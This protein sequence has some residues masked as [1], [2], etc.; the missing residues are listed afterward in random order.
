MSAWASGVTVV[1]TRADG[2][3]HGITASSFTSVSLDPPLIERFR[4]DLAPLWPGMDSPGATLGL[5]VSGGGD[6]LALLLLARAALPGRVK[7]ATVDHGLRPD[8]AAEARRAGEFCAALGI[9]HTIR[10]WEG[11]KPVAGLQAAA[12]EA[13]YRLLA[14]AA[15][16]ADCS[17]VMTGHTLDDQAETVAMRRERGAGRGLSGIAPATLHDKRIWFVRPLIG[18]RRAASLLRE[19][20][21]EVQAHVMESLADQR[22]ADVLARL[23]YKYD[24]KGFPDG[25]VPHTE[26]A[27]TC[28]QVCKAWRDALVVR[29]SSEEKD[30]ERRGVYVLRLFFDA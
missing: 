8:S 2:L 22:L 19:L 1:T 4:G 14:E 18:Q 20:P 3:A 5:A 15:D 12:R 7:A 23:A 29:G 11:E 30:D 26:H 24:V 10:R 9:P 28:M 13:R 6:S 25:V 16:D 27:E 21:H 17:L